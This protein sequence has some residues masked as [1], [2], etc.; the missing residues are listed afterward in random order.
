MDTKKLNDGNRTLDV[1]RNSKKGQVILCRPSP[2]FY[3]T[4]E[5]I[6]SNIDELTPTI[7]RDVVNKN[8]KLATIQVC[9]INGTFYV[10]AVPPENQ[11]A[12][13]ASVLPE[14]MTTCSEH[15]I[16]YKKLSI[17]IIAGARE[18]GRYI[19]PCKESDKGDMVYGIKK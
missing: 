10:D 18:A 17:F 11:F 3:Q 8:F 12:N 7:A 13:N 15:Y 14:K 16:N 1:L 6:A 4:C 5:E 9:S 2:D 19:P